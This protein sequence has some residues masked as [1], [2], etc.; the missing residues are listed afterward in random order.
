[1]IPAGMYAWLVSGTSVTMTHPTRPHTKRKHN[2][3]PAV[4]GAP[5]RVMGNE[6]VRL[7][8]HSIGVLNGSLRARS[9]ADSVH[10]AL[11]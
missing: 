11:S 1:M 2:F 7:F 8:L 5:I 3:V 4:P 10:E 9:W 6:Y